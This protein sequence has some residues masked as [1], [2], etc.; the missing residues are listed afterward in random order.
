MVTRRNSVDNSLQSPIIYGYK[1]FKTYFEC[2]Y[3]KLLGRI[4]YFYNSM[5]AMLVMQKSDQPTQFVF[6]GIVSVVRQWTNLNK[7][8][9][10]P[11]ATSAVTSRCVHKPC[12]CRKQLHQRAA[13]AL[14]YLATANTYSSIKHWQPKH[15]LYPRQLFTFATAR[16]VYASAELSSY[17]F[18]IKKFWQTIMLNTTQKF[19]LSRLRCSETYACMIPSA[20]IRNV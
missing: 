2:I 17:V 8:Q 18:S 9:P 1:Q 16:C 14:Q 3:Q 19:P 6:D 20:N 13:A 11:K 15:V 12:S 7:I 5:I 4:Q 10:P